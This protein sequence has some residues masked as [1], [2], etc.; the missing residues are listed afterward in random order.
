[1][2]IGFLDVKKGYP[3]NVGESENRH[4]LLYFLTKG[5]YGGGDD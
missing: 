3:Y 2:R 4:L 5:E 1:M